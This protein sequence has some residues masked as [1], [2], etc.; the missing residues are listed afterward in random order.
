[1]NFYNIIFRNRTFN[2]I[3]D[4]RYKKYATIDNIHCNIDEI[5][6]PINKVYLTSKKCFSQPINLIHT[7]IQN[8]DKLINHKS[9]LGEY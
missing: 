6:S 4:W 7:Q 8:I 1:M 2:K 9:Y 3:S 5:T